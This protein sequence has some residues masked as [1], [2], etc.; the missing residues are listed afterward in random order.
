MP[1]PAAQ[2]S[3]W[4]NQGGTAA[5]SNAYSAIS[6]ALQAP[7]ST[8]RNRNFEIFLQGSYRNTTNIYGDS[9]VDVVLALNET[10]TSNSASLTPHDR[11]LVP[12]GMPAQYTVQM[13]RNDVLA[14]LRAAFGLNRVREGR[15][16]INVNTGHGREAD[17]IPSIVYY[18]YYRSGQLSGLYYYEGIAFLSG[19]Q[20]IYNFPK[21]H[22]D[23][24]QAKNIRTNG[25]YKPAVR[26]FKN[27][28][29]GAVARKYLP[30][31]DAPSYFIE[32]LLYN[33]PDNLFVADF[34]QTFCGVFEFLHQRC[35]PNALMSQNGIIPLLG[36]T[37]TQWQLATAQRFVAAL[38]RLWNEWN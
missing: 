35:V 13:F 1:I 10:T 32:G 5:S 31:A 28:R 25:R 37:S 27:A 14:S 38:A 2:L 15:R 8:V 24:G 11:L 7:T 3:T 29:N 9:D 4:T 18:H 30:A 34:Q 20:W 22:I 17:V 19:N 26:M 36:A 21:Q 33:V 12:A 23:N 16:A 6:R